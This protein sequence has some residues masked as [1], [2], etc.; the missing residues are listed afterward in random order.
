MN[1]KIEINKVVNQ[2]SY[3]IENLNDYQDLTIDLK[4]DGMD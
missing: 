1:L 3:L 2:I 4:D